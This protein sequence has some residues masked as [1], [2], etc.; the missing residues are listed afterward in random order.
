MKKSFQILAVV[1]AVA[2]AGY[3][4]SRALASDET[5]IRWLIEDTIEAFN[6]SRTG[7]TVEGLDADF[8]E[9]TAKLRRDEVKLI[10]IQLFLQERDPQTKDFRFRVEP[11]K[12]EVKI[13]PAAPLKASL[14]LVV[15]FLE[16]RGQTFVPGW[17]IEVDASL[18]KKDDGWKIVTSRHKTLKGKRSF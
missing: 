17:T 5:R 10:A 1:V 15:E 7:G 11:G 6:D 14:T 16:L 12:L 4:L 9:E 8:R 13:D 18:E 3:A 2:A